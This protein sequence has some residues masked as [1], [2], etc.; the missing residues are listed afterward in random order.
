PG[1]DTFQ[2]Y[3]IRT[4]ERVART[5]ERAD[6]LGPALEE[7]DLDEAGAILGR[8]PG[9]WRDADAKLEAFVLSA[10]PEADAP[11]IQYLH[12]HV[13]R[14]EV[15]LQGSLRELEGVKIEMLD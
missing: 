7:Q 2:A 6:L 1:L 8:R 9:S 10:G 14:H 3:R 15:L 4:A 5:L 12:R 11:L 13:Q